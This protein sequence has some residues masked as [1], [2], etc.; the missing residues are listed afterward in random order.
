MGSLIGTV[1]GDFAPGFP[2]KLP[3]G[4]RSVVTRN[5]CVMRCAE[6]RIS[7]RWKRIQEGTV[8]ML[9]RYGVTANV[10]HGSRLGVFGLNVTVAIGLNR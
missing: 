4:R 2:G 9:M 5:S 6:S 7:T 8:I 10:N 3:F 1:A